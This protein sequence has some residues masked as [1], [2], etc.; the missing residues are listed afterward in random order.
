MARNATHIQ[1]DEVMGPAGASLGTPVPTSEAS[2]PLAKHARVAAAHALLKRHLYK[3][4]GQ[5]E[6]ALVLG[7][8]D[9]NGPA[10][11]QLHPHGSSEQVPL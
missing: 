2:T 5:C 1:D 8:V 6:C 10:L 3:S 11:W 4:R 7:G 9:V